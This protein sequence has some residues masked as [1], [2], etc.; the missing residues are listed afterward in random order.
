[1]THSR[2]KWNRLLWPRRYTE[3]LVAITVASYVL[4]QV[5]AV[6]QSNLPSSAGL[7]IWLGLLSFVAVGSGIGAMT[8]FLSRHHQNQYGSRR[9]AGLCGQCGYDLRATATVRCPECGAWHGTTP[10]RRFGKSHN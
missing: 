6:I 2:H 1:M 4:C 5:S 8:G 9:A 10:A 3:L 7:W